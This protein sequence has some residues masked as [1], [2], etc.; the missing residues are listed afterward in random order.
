MA[1][2]AHFNVQVVTG[3]PVGAPIHFNVTVASG[4]AQVIA[5]NA[6][7]QSVTGNTNDNIVATV[8]I[9]GGLMSANSQLRICSLWTYPNNA[10][11]KTVRTR[12]GGNLMTQ[13]SF[14]SGNG[15]FSV[16]TILANRGTGSQVFVGGGFNGFGT[17]GAVSTMAVDTT[18]DQTVTFSLQLGTSTDTMSLERFSIEVMTPPSP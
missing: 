11:T 1:A 10:N 8:T 14:T 4:V 15:A 2:P 17:A 13:S 18:V 3:V 16:E 7:Q 12:F 5:A 6:T 9:P